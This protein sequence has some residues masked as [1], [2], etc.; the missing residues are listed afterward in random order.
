V[1][2]GALTYGLVEGTRAGFADHAWAFAVAAVALTGFVLYERRARE[3]MLPFDLFR[4][5]N[6][7]FANLE[8]FV[9]YAAL[10][11]NFVF[12]TIFMQFLGFTPFQ[13]GLLQVPT[14][15]VI[16]ALAARF[17]ALADRHGPR[18]YLTLGPTLFGLGTLCT[19]LISEKSDFWTAGVASLALTSVG[20]AMLV[21]PI[22][23]TALKSAPSQYAGI[24]S[25]V[26][27]TV[28]RLGSTLAIAIIGL[29]IA[30]VFDAR[31]DTK[32]AV[33]LAKDQ[34][35]AELRDASI[36]GFRVGML[37]VAGLSFAGAA[38]GALGISNRDAQSLPDKVSEQAPVPAES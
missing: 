8:T 3:P 10:Y 14:S 30:L 18:L 2:F 36:D 38:V 37:V 15:L 28:S 4:R 6:F 5:R 21:A 29:V 7:A 1:G 24:A 26:N 34:K 13:A 35:S 33:P 16:F 19:L 31:T 23:A 11:G 27:S 12:F 25:G 22:T 20:L 32:D 9:V 17:G